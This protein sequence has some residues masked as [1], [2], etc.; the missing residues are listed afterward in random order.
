VRAG[1]ADVGAALVRR[2]HAVAHRRYEREEAAARRE[3]LA[4]WA[5][6]FERPSEWRKARGQ[7]RAEAGAQRHEMAGRASAEGERCG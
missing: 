3:V 1:G 7:R 5:G 2:G 6:T 4:L